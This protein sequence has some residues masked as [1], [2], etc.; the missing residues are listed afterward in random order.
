MVQH[1]YDWSELNKLLF[2]N[3]KYFVLYDILDGWCLLWLN[4]LI[5]FSCWL[6]LDFSCMAN[7]PIRLPGYPSSKKDLLNNVSHINN[8]PLLLLYDYFGTMSLIQQNHPHKVK[9]IFMLCY[10]TSISLS[11]L[12]HKGAPLRRSFHLFPSTWQRSHILE[13][14]TLGMVWSTQWWLPNNYN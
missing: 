13:N 9:C 14:Y 4:L 7:W 8:M 11:M 12:N 5:Q 6:T 10:T 3:N 1:C 2:A